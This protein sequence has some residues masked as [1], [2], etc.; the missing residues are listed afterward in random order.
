MPSE[1]KVFGWAASYAS[2]SEVNRRPLNAS[3]SGPN[4]WQSGGTRSGLYGGWTITS[5][6]NFRSV[7]AV[8]AAVCG[9][10]LSCSNKTAF[11]SSPRCFLRIAG[12]SLSVSISL[13]RVLFIVVPLSWYCSSTGPCESQNTVASVF[14]RNCW[15]WTFSWRGLWV[16]AFHTLPFTLL[17]V[18]MDPCF[19][20]S[21]DSV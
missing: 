20:T 5:N 4:K 10:A 1:K 17:L 9:R 6:F 2:W 14:L 13:Y 19:V 11:D 12:F 15:V 7:L 3:L 21:D 16:F 18:T 8:W